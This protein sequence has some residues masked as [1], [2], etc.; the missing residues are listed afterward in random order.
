MAR[1]SPSSV[2]YRNHAPKADSRIVQYLNSNLYHP[3][4]SK[5]GDALLSFCWKISF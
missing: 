3:R 2:Q 5:H 1:Q 4:S